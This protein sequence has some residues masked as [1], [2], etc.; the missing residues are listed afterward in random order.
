MKNT[1]QGRLSNRTPISVIDIGSN[2]VRLVV[3]EGLVRAPTVLFNEKVLCGLGKNL[4]STGVLNPKAVESVLIALKR[5]CALSHQAGATSLYILATA[6]VREARN[7]AHFIIA[8]QRILKTQIRVLT[9][10]EEAYYSAMGVISSFYKPDGIAGD[11]G[12]G[13]LELVDINDHEIGN[14]ITLPLGGLHLSDMADGSLAQATKIAKQELKKATVLENA[15][16]RTF[17]A[18]GGTWRNF[19]KLHMNMVQYPLHVMHNFEVSCEEATPTL[20]KLAKGDIDSLQGIQAISR[21]RQALLSYGAVVLLEVIQK[22]QPRSIVMSSLGVREGFLYSLLC[23]SV[24]LEDPLLCA[25]K[26]VSILH[27]RSPLHAD[28][29]VLWV[30]MAFE[31]LDILENETE[32]RYRK[33]TCL[34]SDI[35]WRAHTDYRGEQSFNLI[36]HGGFV[37]IDHHGRIFMAL[38]NFYRQE[39]LVSDVF[40]PPLIKLLPASLIH[41]AKVLGALLRVLYLYSAAM[42]GVL[43]KLTLTATTEGNYVLSIPSACADL[44]SERTENRL[45]TFSKLI[46]KSIKVT[47]K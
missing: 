36:V 37:G 32:K 3:Y 39:G 1:A 17:Y 43:S 10:R 45:D 26:E 34:L 38:A 5:F 8:A 16:G 12:G 7:G 28:E 24:Q 25:S 20:K 33:A 41:S 46:G 47:I 15:K 40:A 2:S 35:G 6:A 31:V 22:M 21:S 19:A 42:P 23:D 18:I 29:L 30:D 14:G 9:G 11:L 13:S 4:A 44:V 27:S